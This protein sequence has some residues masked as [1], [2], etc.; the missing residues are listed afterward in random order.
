MAL[1][2]HYRRRHVRFLLERRTIRDRGNP[3]DVDDTVLFARYKFTRLTILFIVDIVTE[4]LDSALTKRS[5]ALT[6]LHKVLVA[7]RFFATGAHF[8]LIGESLGVSVA[9]VCRC[10]FEVARA[11]VRQAKK[12][13]QFPREESTSSVKQGFYRIS[14][15]P[16]VIGAIDGTLIRIQAPVSNVNRK[17]FHSLNV[18]MTCDYKFRITNCVAK[19]PGSVHDSRMFR[20]SQLCTAFENGEHDGFLLGDSGYPCRKFLLTPYN[21]ATTTKQKKYNDA[22][23]KTRVII[24][25]TFGI[26]KR[27]FPCLHTGMRV[28]PDKASL[29]TLSC[30]VLHNIGIY[31]GDIIPVDELVAVHEENLNI[32]E[33]GDGNALRDYICRTYFS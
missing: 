25:Q 16:N 8:R 28:S 21:A 18:Q 32:Y 31:K 1:Q 15:F 20:E 26:L 30:V 12:F 2:R 24:E 23:C 14:G 22:L 19:W 33:P 13:I 4:K 27:R 5:M 6:P 11:L 9:T 7:L 10:V 17:G 3:M 29:Y